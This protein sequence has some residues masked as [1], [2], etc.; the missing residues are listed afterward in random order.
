MRFASCR[1]AAFM[2]SSFFDRSRHLLKFVLQVPIRTEPTSPVVAPT[3]ERRVDTQSWA[4]RI[5]L[6]VRLAARIPLIQNLIAYAIA[7]AIVCYA[8]R[9]GSLRHVGNAT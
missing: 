7:A 9:G 1:A 6:N 2:T 5:D 4:R 8:A 3:A